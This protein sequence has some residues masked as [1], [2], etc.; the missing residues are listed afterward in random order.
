MMREEKLNPFYSLLVFIQKSRI[1]ERV[2]HRC[3]HKKHVAHKHFCHLYRIIR[4]F[5]VHFDGSILDQR[6]N[7]QSLIGRMVIRFAI[8]HS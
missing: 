6:H 3:G 8:S 2:A 5:L 4:L 7:G 1:T